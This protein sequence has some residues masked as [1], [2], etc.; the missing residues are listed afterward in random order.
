MIAPMTPARLKAI[1]TLETSLMAPH[2]LIINSVRV[3]PTE[4][5]IVINTSKTPMS[6]DIDY[7]IQHYVITNGMRV[8]RQELLKNAN[9]AV[10]NSRPV[11][12][13]PAH[14]TEPIVARH[15]LTLWFEWTI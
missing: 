11:I 7:I 3:H 13:N 9:R 12:I 14:V 1:S 5:K 8:I 6:K 2:Y 4:Q 15:T 10:V